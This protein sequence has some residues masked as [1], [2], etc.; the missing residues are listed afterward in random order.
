MLDEELGGKSLTDEV[1]NNL[2]GEQLAALQE[3]REINEKMVK[4]LEHIEESE[5]VLTGPDWGLGEPHFTKR[6]GAMLVVDTKEIRT[7]KITKEMQEC[8]KGV[9][10]LDLGN[11]AVVQRIAERYNMADHLR[12]HLRSQGP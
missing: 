10:S 12:L 3:M 9:V 11:L 4:T 5:E 6:T 2:S 1:L 7:G 8:L